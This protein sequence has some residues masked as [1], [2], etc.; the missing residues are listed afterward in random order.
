MKFLQFGMRTGTD[1]CC[2]VV[3]YH[4]CDLQRWPNIDDLTGI[5]IYM[6]VHHFVPPE[7]TE[8]QKNVPTLSGFVN[9]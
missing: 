5:C 4:I 7:K 9:D 3:F 8:S 2:G 1:A 6:G